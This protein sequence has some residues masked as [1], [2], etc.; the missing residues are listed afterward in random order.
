MSDF[1]LYDGA[2]SSNDVQR[3]FRGAAAVDAGADATVKGATAVLCGSVAA[4]SSDLIRT[5]YA[6]D[7]AWS[8]VSAPAGAA[9]GVAFARPA[10]PV[11]EVT[12]PAEGT[13]VFKLAATGSFGAASEDTVTIVRD[14]ANGTANVAPAVDVED[15]KSVV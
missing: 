7:V 5:G 11:T 6:G 1:R 13:Y 14:D 2:M 10:N 3:L 12:L 15:R 9:D 4:K 8:L